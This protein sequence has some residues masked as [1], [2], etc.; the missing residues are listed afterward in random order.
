V[1]ECC[2]Q[3]ACDDPTTSALGRR[4]HANGRGARSS[5]QRARRSECVI[6]YANITIAST[7]TGARDSTPTT[8]TVTLPARAPTTTRQHHTRIHHER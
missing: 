3:F 8:P 7:R 5:E 2:F 1:G 4:R 6:S